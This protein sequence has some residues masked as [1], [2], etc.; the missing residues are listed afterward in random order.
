MVYGK[1][2]PSQGN[3]GKT[4][5]TDNEKNRLLN[6][7][8]MFNRDLADQHPIS[9]ITGLTDELAQLQ[10]VT[11]QLNTKIYTV[12]DSLDASVT[13][14]VEAEVGRAKQAESLIRAESKEQ[15]EGLK[16]EFNDLSNQV[17][18]IKSMASGD[19]A[20]LPQINQLEE[21]LLVLSGNINML[22][23]LNTETNN[24]LLSLDAKIFTNSDSVNTKVAQ[25]NVRYETIR[26]E[27]QA[28]ITRLTGED[29]LLARRLA[30]LE[31]TTDS[32]DIPTASETFEQLTEELAAIKTLVYT[33]ETNLTQAIN[34]VQ[35]DSAELLTVIG[36]EDTVGSIQ[37]KLN[38][39]KQQQELVI[40]KVRT[41]QNE[42]ASDLS[43]ILNKLSI[44][45]TIDIE[46]LAN[47]QNSVEE[48][49][50]DFTKTLTA[51]QQELT[52][53]GATVTDSDRKSEQRFADIETDVSGLKRD[54][55]G[56][57]TN[58]EQLS[59]QIDDV[60]TIL[61]NS[62]DSA[63]ALVLENLTAETA[64]LLGTP[65]ASDKDVSIYGTRNLVTKKITELTT[66]INNQIAEI[67]SNQSALNNELLTADADMNVAVQDLSNRLEIQLGELQEKIKGVSG[68]TH[69][70]GVF[71]FVD[72]PSG[73]LTENQ[74]LRPRT[75]NAGDVCIVGN[76][77]F[78]YSGEVWVELGD[79]S[80][81]N[82]RVTAVETALAELNTT[83]NQYITT[84]QTIIADLNSNKLNITDFT[85]FVNELNVRETNRDKAIAESAT[86]EEL[87]VAVAQMDT[88][89]R[90]KLSSEALDPIK[91]S[92]DEIN[93]TLIE[94][95][96]AVERLQTT[97]AERDAIT[98][99]INAQTDVNKSLSE[100]LETKVNQIDFNDLS[101]TLTNA[102]SQKL[103]ASAFTELVDRVAALQNAELADRADIEQLVLNSITKA[104]FDAHIKTQQEGI[105]ALVDII[106]TKITAD[107]LTEAL[108]PILSKLDSTADASAI[109]EQIQQLVEA[110]A[111]LLA[112]DADIRHTLNTKADATQVQSQ[113]DVHS[114]HLGTLDTQLYTLEQHVTDRIDSITADLT[115][116]ASVNALTDAEARVT[117]N[118]N[119]A[120]Q[121]LQ[122][123]IGTK[124][125][126]TTFNAKTD[127]LA[128]D[129]HA[130]EHVVD[131]KANALEV[132]QAISR[133]DEQLDTKAGIV[134]LGA[135]EEE[136][137]SLKNS[138][139]TIDAKLGTKVDNSTFSTYM[140]E[141]AA[142]IGSLNSRISQI[143]IDNQVLGDI[144]GIQDELAGKAS[145]E[146]IVEVSTAL[147]NL[148]DK[149]DLH[150]TELQDTL[151]DYATT[152]TLQEHSE[153]YNRRIVQ[154]TSDLATLG[155]QAEEAATAFEVYK[156]EQASALESLQDTI[157]SSATED[158]V[159]TVMS[160][161][162]I[163]L[164]EKLD[165]SALTAIDSRVNV[166]SISV[167]G[168]I[169]KDTQV[170]SSIG[171]LN[172]AVA[173]LGTTKADAA[174]YLAFK[175]QQASV[176]A[177][178]SAWIN[179]TTEMLGNVTAENK[180]LK[181]I[182]ENVPTELADKVSKNDFET[183]RDTVTEQINE[184][185]NRVYEFEGDPMNID[186]FADQLTPN[187]GD[188][189]VIK[190]PVT[191][192]KSAY[193]YDRTNGW[194]ACDGNVAADKVIIRSDIT[195][196]GDFERIGNFTKTKTGSVP[197]GSAG[198]SVEALLTRL[199]SQRIQPTITA[200]PSISLA[201]SGASA[202]SYEAGSEL[203]I[204]YVA[205]F[206]PGAYTFGPA[207]GIEAST[208][209]VKLMDGDS[210]LQ[211][212][213]TN[214]G[215]FDTVT[216]TDDSAL[217]ITAEAE[218]TEGADA[219]DNLGAVSSPTVKITADTVDA[220]SATI[221]GYRNYF[222]GYTA[223]TAVD[224]ATISAANIRALLAASKNRPT[225]LTTTGM[226]QIIVAVPSDDEI[227]TVEITNAVTTAPAGSV[228][229]VRDV[230]VPGANGYEPINYDIF[231]VKNAVAETGA[232]SS[233][234]ITYK[235][236]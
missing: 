62:I 108:A 165:E 207:T 6:H 213:T 123:A 12:R 182:I 155:V 67:V 222:C 166:L 148:N 54:Y 176:N 201:L 135:A 46:A 69:F 29:T 120:R 190:D 75:A 58:T 90:S 59:N 24:K 147:S 27:L 34:V 218:Y 212:L 208:W 82:E 44:L 101:R 217:A 57:L 186:S 25:L 150:K 216:I 85:K 65:S 139:T 211:T 226:Q 221:T 11:R 140:Q 183:F 49:V 214:E 13:K 30:L 144:E 111:I 219:L 4:Y 51:V 1:I 206:N 145:A 60:T 42:H 163:K 184:A 117:G 228:E 94:L 136:I 105:N 17:A 116:K 55:Y 7:D 131:T 39:L 102:I 78:I 196:A 180:E 236:T 215:T 126:I 199:L 170:D 73:G 8:L 68:T 112:N 225:A 9:A 92:I 202:T 232:T 104:V 209:S 113:F 33:I 234:K 187:S 16:Q 74:T 149:V 138:N 64:S 171:T 121:V 223:N 157:I 229:V 224:A 52:D 31:S 168:L 53:I 160:Q 173:D 18:Q 28:A 109:Q 204:S 203:A 181:D 177:S 35:L 200:S 40:E 124:V 132:N 153:E 174:D 5:T 22:E 66:S 230:A 118:L 175:T 127:K 159:E 41:L 99:F 56:L 106:D 197:L 172:S 95:D 107:D 193:S 188:V 14:L 142:A 194:I 233:W 71:D 178:N 84:Q 129:L 231:Y 10:L 96:A 133:I 151:S 100:A 189:I 141:Q 80:A 91:E 36:D 93:D 191:L 87:S 130:L 227:T 77:E 83:L 167:N 154:L 72:I 43:N 115:D 169:A 61:E 23:A 128:D 143:Y 19:S 103:D 152:S 235:T 97:K 220:S 45:D 198:L 21:Q 119:T 3:T 162:D 15:V 79:S 110:Q 158:I 192:I 164:E 137:R 20:L 185:A 134:A 125:D 161:V 195:L 38:V 88:A 47:Q 26:A 146:Q 2:T 37:Y 122:A 205:T 76:K 179:A 86:K 81:E 50:S 63:K 98:D 114:D 89:V 48:T 210:V 156:A 32:D 70:I